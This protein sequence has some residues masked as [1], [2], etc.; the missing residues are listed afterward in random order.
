MICYGVL[1][2]GVTL[3]D[4]F[5]CLLFWWFIGSLVV[6]WVCWLAAVV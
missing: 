1:R 2:L 3:M 6:R 5:C 4:L